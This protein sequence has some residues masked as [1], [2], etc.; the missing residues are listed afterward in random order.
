MTQSDEAR[1]NKDN[2]LLTCIHPAYTLSAKDDAC[3]VNE[4]MIKEFL[5]ALADI[6]LT[7]A[8]R[9]VEETDQ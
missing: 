2:S 8:S 5:N 6:S 4:L 9:K 1:E 7:I 3:E